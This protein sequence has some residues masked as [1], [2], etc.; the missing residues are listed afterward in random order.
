MN[1]SLRCELTYHR[2]RGTSEKQ[3][4]TQLCPNKINQYNTLS[5][6]AVHINLIQ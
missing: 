2:G 5:Q 4:L 6:K 3:W 1:I